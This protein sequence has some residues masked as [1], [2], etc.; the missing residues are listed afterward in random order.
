MLYPF[1]PGR[2]SGV[3]YCR[4]ICG[5]GMTVWTWVVCGCGSTLAVE[6]VAESTAGTDSDA[7][8]AG[9]I[10]GVLVAGTSG[11]TRTALLMALAVWSATALVELEPG[12]PGLSASKGFT[13]VWSRAGGRNRSEGGPTT[14]RYP[15]SPSAQ[16][17]AP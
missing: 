2:Y 12:T 9:S 5:C 10:A 17:F 16:A 7:L 13:A 8:V 4:N 15:L 3:K 6:V 11:P 14:R 1:P